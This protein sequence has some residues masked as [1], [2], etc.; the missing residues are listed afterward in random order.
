MS[1]STR[2]SRRDVVRAS[3]T[4]AAAAAVGAPWIARAAT[5][6]T[7][8][9]RT[10][11][12]PD[13]W[14][15]SLRLKGDWLVLEVSDGKLS[16]YGEASQSNDDDRC[17]QVAAELFAKHYASFTPSLDD[18]ARKEHEIAA[19]TPDLVTQAALSGLNQAFYDLLAKR[20]GVPVWRLFRDRAPIRR[21]AALHDDQPRARLAQRR[22]VLD[23]RRRA[24]AAG[25]QDVQVRAI[26]GRERPGACGREE[27]PP[28]FETLRR[29][30]KEF[31][32]LGCASIFTSAFS[33][34][35]STRLMPDSSGSSLDWIE[36]P[37]T[38]GPVT[39]ELKSARRAS[40]SPGGEL[41]W[42]RQR[43]EEIATHHW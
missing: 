27:R 41:F 20:E 4:A 14:H 39:T 9:F 32:E 10:I 16:G 8:R 7:L 29:L 11:R 15:P 40:G 38:V 22:R 30:R 36:E 18:L 28:G 43:F 5:P 13:G 17:K 31:P 19:L 34:R 12:D 37:F 2:L 1:D 42:G 23:D 25:F 21:A 35:T 3:A 26:R 24:R 33:P 6:L